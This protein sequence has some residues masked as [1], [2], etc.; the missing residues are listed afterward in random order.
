MKRPSIVCP[1]VAP[2]FDWH[3]VGQRPALL[4]NIAAGV[5]PTVFAFLPLVRAEPAPSYASPELAAVRF[6]QNIGSSLP[7]DVLMSDET[8]QTKPLATFFKSRPVVLLFGYARCPQLCSVIATGMVESLRRI[9]P[10]VSRDYDVIYVSIDPTD[11]PRDLAALKR[12]DVRRYGRTG[13][14]LGWHDLGGSP[15]S[16]EQI[17]SAAGFHFTYDPHTKLYAHPSGFI[18]ITPGGVISQYFVGIEFDPKNVATAVERAA[19]GKTGTSV[20]DLLLVCVRG[21]GV[22]GRY[23]RIIWLTLD[24]AVALTVGLL[25]WGIAKMLRA[26]RRSARGTVGGA[27]CHDDFRVVIRRGVKPLPQLPYESRDP[28]SPGGPP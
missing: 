22:G 4:R 12:R 13:A 17:A 27:L 6:D 5:L 26:E 18:V 2:V 16:I 28:P 24:L 7:L 19:A 11:T 15:D 8:G 10:T 3:S 1:R 14:E 23:G 9:T 21:A 25:G 20:F